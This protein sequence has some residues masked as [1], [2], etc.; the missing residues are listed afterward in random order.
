MQLAQTGELPVSS[1]FELIEK[2]LPL[3]NSTLLELG[4]GAAFTTR[5]IVENFPVAHLIAAEV[6]R[7]QH[8]KNLMVTDLPKVT[9]KLAGMDDT[10]E[11]DNSMDAVIILN[12]LHHVP[13]EVITQGFSEIHRILKPGGLLYISEPVFAGDFNEILRLFNNE[14]VVRK[15]AFEAIRSAVDSGQFTLEK[16]IHFISESR[17]NGF[18]DFENRILGATHSNFDIDEKLF[19][20]V[21]QHFVSYINND[22]LAIFKNPMRVDLLRKP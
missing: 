10:G 8:E 4:C 7:I 22:G 12:P 14:E 1:D 6:D 18:E 19:Q 3:D 20:Q 2:Y 21:R 9:F 13:R 17:F 16:E 5:R 15:E 11:A